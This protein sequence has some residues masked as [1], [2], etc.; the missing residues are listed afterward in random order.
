MGRMAICFVVLLS[1]ILCTG[2]VSSDYMPV[3]SATFPPRPKKHIIDVY[4]SQDAPVRIHQELTDSKPIESVPRSALE[5][6]RID[7]E[8]SADASWKAVI[9]DAKKKARQ[10]GGDG[11]VIKG[12]GSHLTGVN[13]YGQTFYGKNISMTVIRYQ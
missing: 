8:G 5:I 13:G 7:T 12:W 3:G 11:I 9:K 2:C 6:G 10:L 1:I 4:L